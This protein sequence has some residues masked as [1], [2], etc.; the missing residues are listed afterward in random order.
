VTGAVQLVESP[1][2]TGVS[3]PVQLYPVPLAHTRAPSTWHVVPHTIT[4]VPSRLSAATHE[5]VP[6]TWHCAA[7]AQVGKQTLRVPEATHVLATPALL[8]PQPWLLVQTSVHH[9]PPVDPMAHRPDA[10]AASALHLSPIFAVPAEPELDPDP[11]LDADPASAA[12]GAAQRAV[13]QL[14]AA[15]KF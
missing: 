11:E 15:A 12:Q 5:T 7:L 1:S 9:S 4:T 10:Q 13:T 3:V 2:V 8:A 14:E 6:K